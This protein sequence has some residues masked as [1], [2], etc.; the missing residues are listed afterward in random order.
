[1]GR[2]VRSNWARRGGWKVVGSDGRMEKV[3][4]V[5]NK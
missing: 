2:G 4:Q 1:M 3:E 5:G